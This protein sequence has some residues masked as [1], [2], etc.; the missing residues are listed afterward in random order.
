MAIVVA[1]RGKPAIVRASDRWLAL[2]NMVNL[3]VNLFQ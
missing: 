2:S 1:I 3:Q